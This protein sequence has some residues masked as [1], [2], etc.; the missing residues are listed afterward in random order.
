[1]MKKEVAK[2]EEL[3]HKV[4][5][6]VMEV[7]SS[8]IPTST[9]TTTTK[10]SDKRNANAPWRNDNQSLGAVSRLDDEIIDTFMATSSAQDG[11]S[12]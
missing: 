4:V 10:I 12:T 5:W 6:A 3:S 9:L 1:M 7:A 2:V 8:T 11:I